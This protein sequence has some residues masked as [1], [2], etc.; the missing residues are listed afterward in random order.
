MNDRLS[1]IYSGESG[2][3]SFARGYIEYVGELLGKLDRTKIAS[4]IDM[5][6][7][8]R[9][10]GGRIFFCGNGGSAVTA[11]HF[12]NDLAIGLAGFGKPFLAV[13]LSD[14]TAMV[15][16]IANDFGYDEIFTYQLRQF[17]LKGDVVVAIS[18]SGQSPN[19]VRALEYA[20]ANGAAT[21]ALTGFDGGRLR[22]I[23]DLSIH[24]PSA[25]GEYGPTED[26]HLLI[27]HLVSSFL[28]LACQKGE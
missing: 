11:S 20:K 19:V 28:K 2:A 23:A 4:F 3:A 8:V 24:V 18:A 26:I 25:R 27:D 5:I 21:V 22:E 7:E 14:N 10:R 1:Q 12:A 15:T 6:L 9:D 13:S 16:S 17:M